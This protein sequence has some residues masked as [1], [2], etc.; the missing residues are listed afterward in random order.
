[1]N[2]QKA[3]PLPGFLPKKSYAFEKYPPSLD[4]NQIIISSDRLVFSSR[5][6]EMIFWSKGHYGVITDG[7]FSV[8]T[9]L[10][11]NINSKGNIDIQA[12]DKNITLYIGNAGQIRLGDTLVQP[13][14]LG[15]SLK[16]ILIE[17]IT[18]MENL[19]AGGLL[20]PAGPV[21]GMNPEMAKKLEQIKGRLGSIL[22]K[23]V[24]VA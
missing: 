10:G 8:D 4:G 1:M 2:P 24:G 16:N 7:I 23:K 15:E 9:E 22:S 20:T 5:I 19:K 13:A 3:I 11:A 6:N 21:S 12:P 14:V 17:I 18:E